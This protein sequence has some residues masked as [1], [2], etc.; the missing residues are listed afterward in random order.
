MLRDAHSKLGTSEGTGRATW[1][2]FVLTV[3]ARG[4]LGAAMVFGA[5]DLCA[6]GIDFKSIARGTLSLVEFGA[7]LTLRC[8]A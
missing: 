4:D 1:T 8:G 3:A 2:K 5:L 6:A 7:I